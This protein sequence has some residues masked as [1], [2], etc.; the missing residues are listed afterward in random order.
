MKIGIF[1]GTFNPIHV[2]HMKVAQEYVWQLE[3]DKL[4]LVPTYIPPHKRAKGL[5]DAQD[6]LAMCALAISDLPKFEV[7][8]YEIQQGGQSYTFKTLHYL[9]EL[10]P[11]GDFYLIMGADMFL[12]VQDWRQPQEI[13]RMATL[14]AAQREQGEFTLVDAHRHRLEIQGARC[15]VLDMQPT[16]MSST[17]I[18]KGLLAGEDV[19]GLLHPDVLEYIRTQR[20]YGQSE[21]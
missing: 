18:R 13:Y 10:Y 12:T 8:D 16:P 1:G 7:S 19:S 21:K 5:A 4:I 3:L 9:K 11:D 15:I 20:L 14:C 6:R 2:V 17:I